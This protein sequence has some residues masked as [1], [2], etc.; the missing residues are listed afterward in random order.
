MKAH[1]MTLFS[2]LPELE[3]VRRLRPQSTRN[4]MRARLMMPKASHESNPN[5]INSRKHSYTKCPLYNR[6]QYLVPTSSPR[7]VHEVI[8]MMKKP[9][10]PR[11]RE[12]PVPNL[13]SHDYPVDHILYLD[14]AQKP[15]VH[16]RINIQTQT[17]PYSPSPP[18]E[19]ER[20][21]GWRRSASSPFPPAFCAALCAASAVVC[22]YWQSI[23]Q[24]LN[25]IRLRNTVA[26]YSFQ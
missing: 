23:L 15:K 16:I 5:T 20:K 26:L 11:T 1:G 19:K 18:S 3:W 7:P 17:S 8:M 4:I 2:L 12:T 14:N 10:H 9:C 24:S 6:I 21:H 22:M 13:H 25:D